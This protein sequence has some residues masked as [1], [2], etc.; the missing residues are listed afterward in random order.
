VQGLTDAYQLVRNTEGAAGLLRGYIACEL[1]YIP[2]F[3]LYKSLNNLAQPVF[4]VPDSAPRAAHFTA[5]WAT[6]V[7]ASTIT[8]ITCFPL[9]FAY[10]RLAADVTM[11]GAAHQFTGI[12]NVWHQALAREGVRG[13]YHGF[14]PSLC[15]SLLSETT[16]MAFA[17]FTASLPKSAHPVAKFLVGYGCTVASYFIT[18]P[19]ITISR[20]ILVYFHPLFFLLF[21]AISFGDY[22]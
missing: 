2:S 21:I 18:Y 1:Q 7:V 11:R 15:A 22:H 10:V 6:M 4:A 16:K 20:R 12:R 19:L 9:R 5:Q 8:S 17:D 14:L 13:L 3:I